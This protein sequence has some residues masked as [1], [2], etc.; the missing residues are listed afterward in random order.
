[1][2]SQGIIDGQNLRKGQSTRKWFHCPSL[3]TYQCFLPSNTSALR[4]LSL[5]RHTLPSVLPSARSLDQREAE[6]QQRDVWSEQ[7]SMSLL[8]TA[9]VS[10]AYP[11]QLNRSHASTFKCL[12]LSA[13]SN[14]SWM[15][16]VFPHIIL[17]AESLMETEKGGVLL[18]PSPSIVAGIP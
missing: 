5:A 2:I 13:H 16:P 17:S 4:W 1:M 14:V 18:P 6:S 8:K 15:S 9:V 12:F 7:E 11:F 10:Q 3:V